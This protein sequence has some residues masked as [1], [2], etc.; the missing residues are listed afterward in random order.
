LEDV[1]GFRHPQKCRTH[2]YKEVQKNVLKKNGQED[3]VGIGGWPPISTWIKVSL[4]DYFLELGM[5]WRREGRIA[6]G[7][8]SHLVAHIFIVELETSSVGLHCPDLSS[9]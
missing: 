5:S 9:Q 6:E 8:F 4:S 3:P 7:G 2:N 1:W